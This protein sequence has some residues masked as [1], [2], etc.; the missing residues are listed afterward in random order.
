[1][2][3]RQVYRFRDV[4]N[5]GRPEDHPVGS[6]KWAES[7]AI[8]L[9]WQTEHAEKFGVDELI[10]TLE[11]IETAEAKPW[12]V[13][14]EEKP[15]GN[16]DTFFQLSCG[17]SVR[18]VKA[19][20]EAYAPD[21]KFTFDDAVTER[22]MTH[23]EAGKTGG[24]GNKASDN[25][26]SFSGRG[27]SAAY[28]LVRIKR[29]RPDIATRYAKGEFKSVRAAAIEAGIVQPKKPDLVR[30]LKKLLEHFTVKEIE[31]ALHEL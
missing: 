18:Q 16:A 30:A 17:L 29:E 15:C 7:L 22:T 31:K 14:P 3:Q 20:V 9:N 25:V 23:S 5:A 12:M 4:M 21:K 24:R 8:A 27:N 11:L 19:L 1:M 28:Q 13:W 10:P 2:M 6:V 26:T